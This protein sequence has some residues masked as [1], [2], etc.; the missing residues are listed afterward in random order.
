MLENDLKYMNEALKE[1]RKAYQKKEIPVVKLSKT[2]GGLCYDFRKF[3]LYFL[4]Y[5]F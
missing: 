5:S 4:S 2:V 3:T 1:A